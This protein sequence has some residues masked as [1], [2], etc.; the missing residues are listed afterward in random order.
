MPMDHNNDQ[1]GTIASMCSSGTY[2]LVVTNTSLIRLK[3]LNK[4]ETMLVTGNGSNY[5][6]LATLWMVEENLQP[7]LD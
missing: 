1:Q 3:T 5:V 7:P 4:R 2:V 6:G